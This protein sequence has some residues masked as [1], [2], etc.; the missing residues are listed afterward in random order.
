MLEKAKNTA[1][2]F[3]PELSIRDASLLAFEFLFKARVSEGLGRIYPEDK[4]IRERSI[5]ID[6][7]EGVKESDFQIATV[8]GREV[9]RCRFRVLNLSDIA[10]HW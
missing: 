1:Y 9:L 6:K 8:K 5:E 7:H 10:S 2:P 3:A 4:R